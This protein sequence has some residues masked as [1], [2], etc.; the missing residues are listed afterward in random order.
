MSTI[1]EHVCDYCGDKSADGRGWLGIAAIIVKRM[2]DGKPILRRRKVQFCG[3]RCL[4][5]WVS[6]ELGNG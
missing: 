3:Q 6:K 1:T 5:E 2:M 4:I